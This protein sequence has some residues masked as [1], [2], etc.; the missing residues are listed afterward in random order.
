[1]CRE[2]MAQRVSG[3]AGVFVNLVQKSLHGILYGAHGAAFSAVAEEERRSI[4]GRSDRAQQLVTLRF[5]VPQRQLSMVAD[6]NDPLLPSLPAHLHL[7]RKQVDVGSIDPTQLRQSHPGG[8]EKLQYRA[9]PDVGEFSLPRLQLRRLKEQLD[10]RPVEITR[11]IFVLLRGGHAARRV[12]VHLLVAMQVLVKAADR[13]KT[14]RD[15]A[16][17]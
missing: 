9:V 3:Q 6:R 17:V 10:L 16:L 8:I 5:V 14:P 13:E 7:L 4:S 15:R 2:G 11:Q 12:R 1:M